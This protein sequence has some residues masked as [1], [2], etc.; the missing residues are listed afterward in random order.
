[1]RRRHPAHSPAAIDA[2]AMLVRSAMA[3]GISSNSAGSAQCKH[4]AVVRHTALRRPHGKQP[5]R[6][7]RPRARAHRMSGRR[8][9]GCG[10]N[11][12]SANGCAGNCRRCR[13]ATSATWRCRRA[14][15][16]T[17]SAV[18]RGSL[19]ASN[20]VCWPPGAAYARVT[21][22]DA[23]DRVTAPTSTSPADLGISDQTHSAERTGH[24]RDVS[25][26]SGHCCLCHG[27]AV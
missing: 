8:S 23:G 26:P 6:R 3:A 25:D 7:Q 22:D 9:R 10:A 12:A 11:G 24:A 4:R 17:R 18:G 19:R 27:H 14:L 21:R 15:F 16:A 13:P 2:S 1:M 5:A 20:G